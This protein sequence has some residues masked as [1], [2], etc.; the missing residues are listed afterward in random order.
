MEKGEQLVTK[1]PSAFQYA[2]SLQVSLCRPAI[3]LPL[4]HIDSMQT[5]TAV[6]VIYGVVT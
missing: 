3:G 5:C 2:L 6:L 1:N 4:H